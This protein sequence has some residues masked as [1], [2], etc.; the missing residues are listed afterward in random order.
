MVVFIWDG[1]EE[2]MTWLHLYT[3]AVF[4][5]RACVKILYTVP[6]PYIWD[7]DLVLDICIT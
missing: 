3:C 2:N 1:R 5:C 7:I 4:G 6:A